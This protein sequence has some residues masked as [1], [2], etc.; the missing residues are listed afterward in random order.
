MLLLFNTMLQQVS[1]ALPRVLLSRA[2]CCPFIV[3]NRCHAS[4][5]Q[6]VGAGGTLCLFLEWCFQARGVAINPYLTTV[7]LISD[8]M[9]QQVSGAS[10]KT[11]AFSCMTLLSIRT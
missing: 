7:I 1:P 11:V 2:L 10:S 5:V 3:P 4:S 9:L 6:C 8:A